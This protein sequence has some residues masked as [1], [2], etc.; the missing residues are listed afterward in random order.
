V[1]FSAEAKLVQV[2]VDENGSGFAIFD[3][4][5]FAES[6]F[7]I[8][9]V[10]GTAF[11]D[12]I[13]GDGT[14]AIANIFDGGAGN[15]DLDGGAGNDILRGGIGAD[16]LDGS[17]GDDTLEGGDGDD[18]LI[19][20]LGAD[21]LVGGAGSD[22]AVYFQ[23]PA[24]RVDLSDPSTNTGIDAI[25][26]TYDSVE[27]VIT[28]I[29]NDRIIGNSVANVLEGGGGG[30]VL[31]GGGGNDTFVYDSASDSFVGSEDLITD[32]T[33]GADKIDI[34]DVVGPAFTFLGGGNQP[35]TLAGPE[36][37]FSQVFEPAGMFFIQR[38]IISGDTDG[39]AAPEFEI[40]L[41]GW[42]NLTASDFIL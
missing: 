30:D 31:T 22:T 13:V 10:V 27:N 11:S 32:F 38:T 9:N 36:L 33:Q 26:D 7:G 1:D 8:E 15:D 17:D 24:V 28:S 29:G 21:K 41:S 42:I 12:R 25:G 37:T 14:A 6:L 5:R 39:D 20:D 18:I 2:F 23:G 16:R 4:T 35:F 3:N 34:S 40:K 19:G